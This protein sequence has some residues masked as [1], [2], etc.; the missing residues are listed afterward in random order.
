MLPAHQRLEAGEGA[1]GELDL[2]LEEGDDLAAV[3]ALQQL[4]EE[5]LAPLDLEAQVLAEVAHVAGA[6]G[7]RRGERDLGVGERRARCR[8]GRRRGA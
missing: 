3:E 4:G 1:G 2:R 8:A 5:R 7:L 6:G